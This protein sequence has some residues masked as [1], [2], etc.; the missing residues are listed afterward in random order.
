MK[1]TSELTALSDAE[2]LDVVVGDSKLPGFAGIKLFGLPDPSIQT[3]T[4]GR[5]G[6]IVL[7]SIY[8]FY[9]FQ[10]E[11][12]FKYG[13]GVRHDSR[14]L[15]F[16]CGWGR[17]IR[18]F[19]KDFDPQLTFGV[20]VQQRLL[21]VARRDVPDCNFIKI[22]NHPP[23]E[24]AAAEF[25][26]IYAY[27]VFS[28]IPERM[29]LQWV[30]EFSRILRPGGIICLT[31]RPRSHIMGVHNSQHHDAGMLAEIIANPENAL[32]RYDLGEFVHYPAAGGA[33]LCE[34]EWGESM[35]PPGYARDKLADGLEFIGFFDEY[36]TSQYSFLQPAIVL[37]KPR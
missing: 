14:I 3:S 36:W 25:D 24:F 2:W 12:L 31:T 9:V 13:N 8:D 32:K 20:D 1:S 10:K 27:S 16:G 29:A 33:Q 18:F 23:I 30:R 37:R 35:I 4:V 22:A 19:R 7:R 6:D 15:D 5:S 21:D 26:L 28:H 34:S 17:I 11:L